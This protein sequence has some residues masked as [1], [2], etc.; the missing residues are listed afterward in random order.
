MGVYGATN[1]PYT[2][3]DTKILSQL[4]LDSLIGKVFPLS[5]LKQAFE[6]YGSRL[7]TRIL[8]QP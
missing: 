2:V 7:Y 1:S 4:S 8:V 5:D 6:A 3:S